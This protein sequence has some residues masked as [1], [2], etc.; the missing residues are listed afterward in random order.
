[1][2]HLLVS[3]SGWGERADSVTTGRIYIKASEAPGN[4]VLTDGELDVS[5]VNRYPALLMTE[6]GGSGS[7]VA[8]VAFINRIVSRGRETAIEYLIDS[9]VPG[10]ANEDIEEFITQLLARYALNHSHWEVCDGDLYRVLYEIRERKLAKRNGATPFFSTSGLDAQEDALVGVM[11]PFAA[12]FDPVFAAIESAGKALDLRCLRAKDILVHH[13]VIQ[14]VIDLIAKARVVICDF[15]GKNSNVFYEAGIAHALGKE[16]I[17]IT[18]SKDDIPFD[19]QHIRYLPYLLNREGT[20][21]LEKGLRERLATL[22][23]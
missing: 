5:K 12:Q 6:I 4:L 15:S 20:T 7:Q 13:H 8:R 1:M 18:Q 10:V 11:M 17:L 3:Y 14:D 19:L 21:E 23:A 9:T 22:T 2:F 16:T